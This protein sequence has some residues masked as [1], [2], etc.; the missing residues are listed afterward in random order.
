MI[1]FRWPNKIGL[2]FLILALI[3]QIYCAIQPIKFLLEH[4]FVMDDAFYYFQI[5]QNFVNDGWVTFDGIH[6]SSGIQLL[7]GLILFM[8]A[9]FVNGDVEF[10]RTILFLSVL[11]NTVA[12]IMLWR[13]GRK[14]YSIEVGDLATI[15]W[16]GFMIGLA[17]TMMGMEYSLADAIEII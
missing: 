3:F 13:L 4:L 7:W 15:L 2:F 5:A 10:L 8:A 17:P 6:S 11:L 9:K 14:L 1:K 12:G 16:S